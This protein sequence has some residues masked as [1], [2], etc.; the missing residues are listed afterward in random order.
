MAHSSAG[1][2]SI[3]MIFFL[4][5]M[6]TY[7]L[8]LFMAALIVYSIKPF[9]FAENTRLV[10]TNVYTTGRKMRKTTIG[11]NISLDLIINSKNGGKR[12]RKT[13]VYM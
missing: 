5:E 6:L 8:N 2:G 3:R 11:Q 1:D 13:P 9:L 4:I 7:I 12:G 10:Q